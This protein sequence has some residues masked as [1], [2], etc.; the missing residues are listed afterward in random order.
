MGWLIL[1]LVAGAASIALLVIWALWP[2]GERISPIWR[3]GMAPYADEAQEALA[4]G[5]S[6]ESAHVAN[7]PMGEI[8]DEG[9]FSPWDAWDDDA[10]ERLRDEIRRLREGKA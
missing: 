7:G 9:A 4:Q 5:P 1:G 8:G 6:P 3:K 10:K 2:W